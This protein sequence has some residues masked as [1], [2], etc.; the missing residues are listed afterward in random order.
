MAETFVHTS[1]IMPRSYLGAAYTGNL[2]SPHTG[3]GS[4]P[5]QVYRLTS[6]LNAMDSSTNP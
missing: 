2:Q 6:F 4:D 5:S 1:L 3:N